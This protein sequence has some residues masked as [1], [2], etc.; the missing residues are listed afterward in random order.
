[1]YYKS[2]FL[3]LISK[4]ICYFCCI[5]EK[6]KNK[7]IGNIMQIPLRIGSRAFDNKRSNYI[8]YTERSGQKKT[9]N[10]NI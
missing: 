5:I 4:F 8:T 6:L 7:S 3:F 1:M 9:I 10:I 2:N